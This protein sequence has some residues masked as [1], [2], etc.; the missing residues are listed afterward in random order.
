MTFTIVI[1]ITLLHVVAGL[2]LVARAF[3]PR[4]D[5]LIPQC[6]DPPN[7]QLDKMGPTRRRYDR[8]R[9]GKW[10]V[11][12]TFAGKEQAYVRTSKWITQPPSSSQMPH[13]SSTAGRTK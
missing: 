4:D 6:S 1:A 13:T 8:A 3:P 11:R 10:T 9:D 12:E 2:H 7:R 5:D